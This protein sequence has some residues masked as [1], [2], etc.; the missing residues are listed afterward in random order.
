MMAKR[1]V[2]SLLSGL[3]LA[4][5]MAGVTTDVLAYQGGDW[6]VR[7]GIASVD[8]NDDSSALN[9]NGT[10]LGGTEATVDHDE[11]LGITATYMIDS[12]L[13]ISLLAAT[14]FEHDIK[15]KGVGASSIDAGSSKQLP[16][17]LTLQ[18]FPMDGSSA[19]QPYLGVGVNFT[20]FFDEDVDGDLESALGAKGDLSLEDSWGLAG[21]VG[22]DYLF[23]EHWMIS[24]SI[25]YLDIDTE[26]EFKFKNGN[27]VTADV[28]IDPWVYMLGVGY[29]F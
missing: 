25:W 5:G 13:G 18:F 20:T 3:V 10:S 17:T 29:K 9:L 21:Q 24:A 7:A 27:R 6:I 1:K 19:F 4:G 16:P 23:N 26:A 11:Q 14:P 28:D 8:P 2:V 12:H 15:A 22:A